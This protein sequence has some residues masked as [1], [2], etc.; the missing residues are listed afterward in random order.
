MSTQACE[1]PDRA[2]D[3]SLDE[4]L[5]RLVAFEPTSLPVISVYLNTQPDEHGRAPDVVP[6]LTREFKAL[7]R[8]WEASSPERKSFDADVD[9]IV[10]YV[11]ESI[12]PAANGVA[13]FA[14][15]GENVFFEALQFS[16]PVAENRIYVYNQ[17][18]LYQL[19]ELDEQYPRYAA[20]VTDANTAR[21]YVFGLGQNL[22]AEEVRGRKCTA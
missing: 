7:S 6:Y 12:D 16:A 10:N 21:I 15:H 1:P 18:H 8:T 19:A 22:N 17:P 14:C 3:E 9:R 2:I 11:G 5:D 4:P 13:L 20:V